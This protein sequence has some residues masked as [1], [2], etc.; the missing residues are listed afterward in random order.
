MPT[1]TTADVARWCDLTAHYMLAAV[2]DATL[3]ETPDP[4]AAY[5]RE[6]SSD[7]LS[8]LFGR[9]TSPDDTAI[10]AAVTAFYVLD[11]ADT[12][13]E[14][15]WWD[16]AGALWRA[17]GRASDHAVDVAIV[18]LAR[19]AEGRTESYAVKPQPIPVIRDSEVAS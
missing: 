8:R 18:E 15:D 5:S 9:A 16:V 14:S 17:T 12:A 11:H 1:P 7:E 10:V 6:L 2:L 4:D 19:E 3:R 13:T